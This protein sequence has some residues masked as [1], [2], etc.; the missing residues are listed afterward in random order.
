[1]VFICHVNVSVSSGVYSP[2][3]FQCLAVFIRRVYVQESSGFIHHVCVSAS[4][5]VYS[6]CVCLGD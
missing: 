6:P 5:D 3:A 4:D 1:M 2:G